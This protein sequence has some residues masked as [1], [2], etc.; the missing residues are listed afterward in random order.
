MQQAAAA[1]PGQN[2]WAG[3]AGAA[4]EKNDADEK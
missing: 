1:A 4:Q 3:P 2:A